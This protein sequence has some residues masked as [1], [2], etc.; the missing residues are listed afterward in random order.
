MI[1]VHAVK[2]VKIVIVR[3]LAKNAFLQMFSAIKLVSHYVQQASITTVEFVILVQLAA[4]HARMP[5]HVL[6]VMMDSLC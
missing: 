1:A 2:I 5:N 3:E 6:Y 4:K